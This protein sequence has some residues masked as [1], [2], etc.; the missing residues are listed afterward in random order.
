MRK[1][2]FLL[3]DMILFLFLMYILAYDMYPKY[4]EYIIYFRLE[5]RFVGRKSVDTCT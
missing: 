1:F 2:V 3:N 4:D 5:I